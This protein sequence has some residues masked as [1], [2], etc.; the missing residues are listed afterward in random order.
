[1]WIRHNQ[2]RF[3]L[4]IAGLLSYAPKCRFPFGAVYWRYWERKAEPYEYEKC[5]R[6]RKL[7]SGPSPQ[8]GE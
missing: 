5:K 1:M 4:E 6:C 7:E 8:D 2:G 3:H